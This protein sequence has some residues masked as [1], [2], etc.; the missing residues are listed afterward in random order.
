MPGS[1]HNCFVSVFDGQ[2]DVSF[3]CMTKKKKNDL[4]KKKKGEKKNGFIYSECFFL[5]FGMLG[6]CW[7]EVG[8]VV[9]DNRH[10]G[11]IFNA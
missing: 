7:M 10:R 11:L 1:S 4:L 8:H 3:Q 6:N 5:E 9:S 2:K